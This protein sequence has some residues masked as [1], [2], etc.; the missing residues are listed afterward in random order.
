MSHPTRV[1]LL[2]CFLLAVAV[3][4]VAA[5]SPSGPLGSRQ[6]VVAAAVTF[7]A[8]AAALCVLTARGGTASRS[9]AGRRKAAFEWNV[10]HFLAP[11]GTPSAIDGDVFK[12]EWERVPWS[13]PFVEIR[14]EADAPPGSGPTAA[15]ETRMKM[16]WDDEYL[17]IAA[18]MDVAAG[19]PIIAKFKERNSP[20]FHTDSDFEV[21]IDPAGCCH[22]YKELE[23]NAINTVWNLMLTKVYAEGGKEISGRIAKPGDPDYYE[24]KA[25]KTATRITKGALE[26]PGAPAQWVCELA[27][28]HRDTLEQVPVAT[29]PAIG[30]HWRI[31]F[32]RVEEKGQ[33][34]WVWSPQV[35]WH[36]RDQRYEGDVNMHAPDSWGYVVF[37]DERGELPGR[38][39]SDS[40]ASSWSDPEWPARRAAMAGYYAVRDYKDIHKQVP[41]SW[42]DIVREGL[43]RG[44]YPEEASVSFHPGLEQAWTIQAQVDGWIASVTNKRLVTVRHAKEFL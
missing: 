22:S 14:G 6:G 21:F 11:R 5:A 10:R 41:T 35:R 24:V 2:V 31:N 39:A 7:A 15:Q 32:S 30:A 42:D 18:V 23:L 4:V 37:A 17:Y 8:L 16:M 19:D 38:G 3:T 40:A 12:P 20:I 34:N 29:T 33:I 26:S 13:T 28:A 1:Q 9:T 25:Q 27:M 44:A 36:A 43:V